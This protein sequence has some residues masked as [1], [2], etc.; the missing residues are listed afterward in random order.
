VRTS[1]FKIVMKRPVPQAIV[2]AAV[3]RL[4]HWIS[5]C[6]LM[7][8]PPVISAITQII[9]VATVLDRGVP[10]RVVSVVCRRQTR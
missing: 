1:V 7:F 8:E 4:G 6:L 3:L 2:K 9:V 10:L 5:M